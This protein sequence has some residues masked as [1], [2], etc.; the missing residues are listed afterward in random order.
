MKSTEY[1]IDSLS[2]VISSESSLEAL[3]GMINDMDLEIK[4]IKPSKAKLSPE[5]NL[6]IVFVKGES[7]LQCS[8]SDVLL[9]PV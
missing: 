8:G 3:M 9:L 4:D 7:E 5:S 1:N 2:S 6:C